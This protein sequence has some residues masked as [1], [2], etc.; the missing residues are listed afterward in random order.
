MTICMMIVI[1][2]VTSLVI[3]VPYITSGRVMAYRGVV[4]LNEFIATFADVSWRV[5]LGIVMA[6]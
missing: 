3:V 6:G 4:I 5:I 2:A 1:L